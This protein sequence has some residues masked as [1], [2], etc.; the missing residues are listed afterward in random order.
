[1]IIMRRNEGSYTDAALRAGSVLDHDR[2]APALAER[3]G[4]D[5]CGG[6]IG[7]PGW[8]RD[9]ESHR[10]FGPVCLSDCTLIE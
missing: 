4:K 6:V 8:K 7:R 10:T 1:V 2:L 3:I 9:Q 5:P